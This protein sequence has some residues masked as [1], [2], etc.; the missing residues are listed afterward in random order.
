V[1]RLKLDVFG[2]SVLVERDDDAWVVFYL[3]GDGK[4]RRADDIFI[5]STVSESEIERWVADLCHEWATPRNP[6]VVRIP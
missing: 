5:P 1:T 6:S 4:R 3:S 2:R